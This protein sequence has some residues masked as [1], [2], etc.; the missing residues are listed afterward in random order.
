MWKFRG[1]K[2]QMV[3]WNRHGQLAEHVYSRCKKVGDRE[4]EGMLE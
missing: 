4:F 2:P 1:S 3:V